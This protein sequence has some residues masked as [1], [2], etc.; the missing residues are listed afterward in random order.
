MPFYIENQS[1]V[2]EAVRDIV[3]DEAERQEFF[4]RLT[5]A[6]REFIEGNG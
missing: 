2:D 4:L 1:I 5:T 3:L 6:Q